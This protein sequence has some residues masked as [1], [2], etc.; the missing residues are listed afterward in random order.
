MIQFTPFFTHVAIRLCVLNKIP[1]HSIYR[2]KKYDRKFLIICVL[3]NKII[4]ASQLIKELKNFN[5][6]IILSVN[7]RV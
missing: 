5:K 3:I 6:S 7:D 2:C 1:L 4:L